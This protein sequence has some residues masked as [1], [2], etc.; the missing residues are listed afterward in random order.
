M[1]MPVHSLTVGWTLRFVVHYWFQTMNFGCVPACWV[2]PDPGAKHQVLQ[3]FQV[4]FFFSVLCYNR[5][6][7]NIVTSIT[8]AP[9]KQLSPPNTIILSCFPNQLYQPPKLLAQSTNPLRQYEL[10][11][12]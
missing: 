10:H 11:Y 1:S 9:I 8:I 7:F 4:Y 6:P 12:L 3:R 5:V 2:L